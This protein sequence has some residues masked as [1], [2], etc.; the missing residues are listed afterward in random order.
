MK[1]GLQ[2]CESSDALAAGTEIETS[3]NE[4]RCAS[5]FRRRWIRHRQHLFGSKTKCSRHCLSV[6]FGT[7]DVIDRSLFLRVRRIANSDLRVANRLQALT[8]IRRE[9]RTVVVF[10]T[11]TFTDAGAFATNVVVVDTTTVVFDELSPAGETSDWT[12][13]YPFVSRMSPTTTAMTTMMTP[14]RVP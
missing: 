6:A 1:Q 12:D 13:P 2:T 3:H 11:L 8:S 7:G 5:K 9:T 14:V 4:N 10:T